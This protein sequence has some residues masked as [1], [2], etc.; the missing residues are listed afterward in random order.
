MITEKLHSIYFLEKVEEHVSRHAQLEINEQYIKRFLSH[1][2]SMKVYSKAF[3]GLQ[4][5]RFLKS[6][7][8]NSELV[9]ELERRKQQCQRTKY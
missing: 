9:L 6:V 3:A 5:H 1:K 7:I 8:L 4:E 2:R